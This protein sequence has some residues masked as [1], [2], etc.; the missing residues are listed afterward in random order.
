MDLF[1]SPPPLAPPTSEEDKLSWLRLLR[2]RRVGPATFHR[3]M[4]ETGFDPQAALDLLPGIAANAGVDRYTI[5]PLP[6]VAKELSMGRKAGAQPLFHGCAGYPTTL[7]DLPDAPPVLWALGRVEMLTRPALALVGARNASSSGGRMARQIARN[8]GAAGFITVSGLARGIDRA[9]HE[10]SLDTGTIAVVAGGIDIIYPAENADLTAKIAETGL[11]LSEQPPGLQ[12]MARHFPK[13]NRIISGL[14]QAV[15]VVEAAT[16]SGS[17][18]TARNAL[19]QGRE[20]LAVPGHPLDARASGCNLLIR[21]GATLVRDAKD[22]IASLGPIAQPTVPSPIPAP[23]APKITQTDGPIRDHILQMVGHAP[24]AEDQL[25][26]D[27]KLPP[28]ALASA[29]LALELDG[30]IGRQPGGL[31]ARLN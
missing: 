22:I 26:R 31:L 11:V 20:V 30:T 28:Q 14:S 9:V 2:S 25:A 12:P 18:I 3:L 21:D 23:V 5:C 27:L 6:V 13:R 19:D 24:V 16:K 4:A 1:S 17:L 8:L 10:A 15:I 7:M 29:L